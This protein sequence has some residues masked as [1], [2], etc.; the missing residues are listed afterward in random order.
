MSINTNQEVRYVIGTLGESWVEP[1]E[2][3]TRGKLNV[4]MEEFYE[5]GGGKS[6]AQVNI[7][8]HFCDTE[9]VFITGPF[10]EL[11]RKFDKNQLLRAETT[12]ANRSEGNQ[13]SYVSYYRS[14]QP[15][16][17][18]ELLEVI[19]ANIDFSKDETSIYLSH[20]PSTNLVMVAT[21]YNG[22]DVI[23]GP[24]AH[25]HSVQDDEV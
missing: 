18:H 2:G 9:K 8:E 3:K 21:N 14:V 20:V 7:R 16:K 23:V 5:Q 24:F 22:E 4:C 11:E 19:I 12:R 17:N 15:V 10:D 1:A 25:V 13:Q 6:Y